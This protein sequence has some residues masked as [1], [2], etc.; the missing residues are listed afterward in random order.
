MNYKEF[1]SQF[2][3]I[4][5]SINIIFPQNAS[6]L[7]QPKCTNKKI[8]YSIL[9]NMKD[10]LENE[11]N[12]DGREFYSTIDD[13]KSKKVGILPFFTLNGFTNV[14]KYNSFDDLMEALNKHKIDAILVDNCLANYT[15]IMNNTLSQIP[16]EIDAIYPSLIF[17]K[18]STIYQKFYQF[19]KMA[20]G[21]GNGIYYEAYYR[22]MGINED[23]FY[24]N[25]TMP[26]DYSVLK[27]LTFHY[28][29]Y[30]FN[31]ENGELVGSIVQFLYGFGRIFCYE[32][33]LKEAA[34]IDEINKAI[35]SNE[36]DIV[37]YFVEANNFPTEYSYTL[38]DEGRL[39]PVIRYANRPESTKWTIYDSPEQLNGEKLGCLKNYSFEYLYKERFPDSEV[40]YYNND[41]EILYFL[42]KEDIK[43]YLT[44]ESIAK[45]NEKKFPDRIAYFNL[46]VTNDLGFAFKK[47]DHTL[48]NE[49]N[50][51]LEKQ[52]VEKLYEKWDVE[53]V[54][55]IIIE[56][57]NYEGVKTI[58]VGLLTESKPF[59]FT[60]NGDI[61]GI[62]VE[63]LYEFARNKN[64]NVDLVEFKIIEDRMKIGESDS[65][66]DITGGEFTITE[67]RAKTVSFSNPIYR[68]FTSLVVRKDM[69]KD[70]IK[71]SI[72]D[73][74][75]N[76]ILDNTA[77]VYSKVGNKTITSSCVFPDI[78]N[79]T[80]IINCSINDF[81]DTDPFTQGIESTTTTDKLLIEYSDLEINNILNANE[82]LKLP[83]IQESN[84]TEHICSEENRVKKRNLFLTIV[85]GV[86]VIG[87][88]I[89]VLR[90]C[91]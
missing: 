58:K 64:Y 28:P 88:F 73:N 59:C 36:Y 41:Y 80:L 26:E 79:Y 29:P 12:I 7:I 83:I 33:D 60:V 45:N 38:L 49:F 47:N 71:L 82:K 81:N 23:G 3:I 40:T 62:E 54:S 27:A 31:D 15:Q 2:T 5:L 16:G 39:N 75:Y 18:N 14:E 50:E 65:D 68:M 43:G 61:K 74:E 66:F 21:N 52:D 30:S 78:F 89:T 32:I 17:Q 84:K 76:Q 70:Q 24:I 91:L 34:S 46:N 4:L 67:E 87:L 44:D 85:G 72:F 20:Q 69:K 53:D 51:F 42:L 55:D 56:K 1:L 22:W 35:Q 77:K 13:L 19:Q 8:E 48:L 37:F 25:K 86:V 57:D 90:F 6:E 9:A 63:L 10:Y 11:N